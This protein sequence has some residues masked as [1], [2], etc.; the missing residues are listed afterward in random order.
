MGTAKQRKGANLALFCT[1]ILSHYKR[2]IQISDVVL[3]RFQRAAF[4]FPGQIT[5]CKK[6]EIKNNTYLLITCKKYL[7]QG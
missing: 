6:K 3:L 4:L 7:E 5:N 2:K 1:F